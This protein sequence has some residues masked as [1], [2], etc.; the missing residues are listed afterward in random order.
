MHQRQGESLELHLSIEGE[1]RL[2]PV[3]KSNRKTTGPDIIRET[4]A[5]RATDNRAG[6]DVS[7]GTKTTFTCF[8]GKC[9]DL[10]VKRG[11]KRVTGVWGQGP[12]VSA[13][14]AGS[15]LLTYALCGYL[16]IRCPEPAPLTLHCAHVSARSLKRGLGLGRPVVLLDM[17]HF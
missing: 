9:S 7:R 4:T 2:D 1:S 10:S 11:T 13:S 16:L 6:P 14:P 15:C 5:W 17:L 12:R 3:T 8:S